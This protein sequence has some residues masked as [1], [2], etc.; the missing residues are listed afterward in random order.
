MEQFFCITLRQDVPNLGEITKVKED[1]PG[2]LF[3]MCVKGQVLVKNNSKVPH[4]STRRA[5]T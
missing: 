4:C 2:N 1:S 3:H 5:L